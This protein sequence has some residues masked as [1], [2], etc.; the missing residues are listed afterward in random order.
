MDKQVSRMALP[1][2]CTPPAGSPKSADEAA[3]VVLTNPQPHS[4]GFPQGGQ[5]S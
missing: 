2:N 1:S 3:P 4:G 5:G